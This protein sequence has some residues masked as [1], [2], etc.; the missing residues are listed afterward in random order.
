MKIARTARRIP[1]PGKTMFPDIAE[2]LPQK[3]PFLFVDKITRVNRDRQRLVCSK[4]IRGDEYFFQGHFPGD[5]V[6]PGVLITEAMA[7]AGILLYALLKPEKAARH[8]KYYL[9][10][11]DARFTGI[12]RPPC[13]LVIEVHGEKVIDG[14]GMASAKAKVSGNIVA[15]ASILFG[16]KRK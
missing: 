12:V 7:Q 4:K 2:V 15:E 3:H 1:S 11:V 5:P 16:V 9:G 14:G 8:P 6:M 10:K 13:T